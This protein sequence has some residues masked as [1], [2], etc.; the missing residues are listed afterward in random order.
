MIR[1]L[2]YLHGDF[3]AY[4]RGTR[5]AV[6][7]HFLLLALLAGTAFA[8]IWHFKA[9]LLR[10]LSYVHDTPQDMAQGYLQLHIAAITYVIAGAALTLALN[11]FYLLYLGAGFLTVGFSQIR[12]LLARLTADH[13]T[14]SF[15]EHLEYGYVANVANAGLAIRLMFLAYALYLCTYVAKHQKPARRGE[16][17]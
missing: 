10:M 6:L 12:G 8:Y 2:A 9:E 17:I 11:R 5:Q 1:L 15:I 13:S 16:N 7:P 4:P 3:T 14:H